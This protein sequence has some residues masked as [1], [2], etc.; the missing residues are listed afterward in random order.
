MKQVISLTNN[1]FRLKLKMYFF[2]VDDSSKHK[3][4]KDVNKDVVSTISHNEC[5]Y[6]LLNEKCLRHS[7]KRI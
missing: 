4:A 3:K 6:V 5:K 7:M 1:F 2:L